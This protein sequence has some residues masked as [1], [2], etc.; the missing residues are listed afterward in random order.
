MY[1]VVSFF[2]VFLGL[3]IHPNLG[4]SK[5][6]E[7]KVTKPQ[8]SGEKTAP[9]KEGSCCQNHETEQDRLR[10]CVAQCTPLRCEKDSSL[11]RKC[12]TLCAGHNT[13]VANR[14]AEVC[15]RHGTQTHPSTTEAFH[16]KSSQEPV[17]M[18]EINRLQEE[19]SADSAN[20]VN[21]SDSPK[22]SE[23]SEKSESPAFNTPALQEKTLSQSNPAEGIGP[24]G[25]LQTFQEN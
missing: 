12:K 9:A 25:E 10:E 16:E 13:S 5:T 22:S 14:L 19:G 21:S 15:A 20:A 8:P 17:A 11:A 6:F 23:D 7:F 4:V 24:Y 18:Q 3:C 1:R 2:L